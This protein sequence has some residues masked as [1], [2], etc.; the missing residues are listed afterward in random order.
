MPAAAG[1]EL[2]KIGQRAMHGGIEM[3][4]LLGNALAERAPI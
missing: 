3:D 1:I 4:G 2:V